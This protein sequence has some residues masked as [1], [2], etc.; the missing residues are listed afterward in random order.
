MT[1]AADRRTHWRQTT[2]ASAPFIAISPLWRRKGFLNA[3]FGK[4]RGNSFINTLPPRNAKTAC[5]SPAGYAAKAFILEKK[6]RSSFFTVHWKAQAFKSTK[7]KRF[8]T[9]FAPI[10]EIKG[11]EQ[12]GKEKENRSIASCCD[13]L[14]CHALF[15]S[16][17]CGRS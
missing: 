15:C 2:S 5:T 16:F 12:N 17:Y 8:C 6:K 9:A 1:G 10:A 4:E 7:R 13:S 14:A 11:G 3:A